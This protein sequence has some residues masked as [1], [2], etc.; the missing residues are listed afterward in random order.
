MFTQEIAMYFRERIKILFTIY[1][2]KYKR[3]INNINILYTVFQL[4]H[5]I[6][7]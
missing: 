3:R 2:Y 4:K 1:I 5:F 6:F 7:F